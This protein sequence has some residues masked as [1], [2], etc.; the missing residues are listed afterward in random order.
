MIKVEFDY[1]FRL[2]AK[3][4]EHYIGPRRFY[5]HNRIGGD[6]WEVSP[7]YGNRTKAKIRDPK[8]ATFLKL[9]LR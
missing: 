3:Q 5:L 8:M 6:D 1:D 2:V 9:K 7:Y 4:C